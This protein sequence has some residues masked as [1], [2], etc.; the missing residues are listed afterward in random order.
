MTQIK[1]NY[2]DGLKKQISQYKL[3]NNKYFMDNHLKKWEDFINDT[4]YKKYFII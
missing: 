2:L 4:K 3:N 1:N